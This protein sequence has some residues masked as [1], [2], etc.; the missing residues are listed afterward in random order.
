MFVSSGSRNYQNV[1]DSEEEVIKLINKKGELRKMAL[2]N[3]LI[4]GRSRKLCAGLLT[5]SSTL[6]LN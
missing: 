4:V 1:L 3:Q 2:K 5:N 6:N